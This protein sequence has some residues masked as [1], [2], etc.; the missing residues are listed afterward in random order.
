MAKHAIAALTAHSRLHANAGKDPFRQNLSPHPEDWHCSGFRPVF[1][2]AFLLRRRLPM[3][4]F[5]HSGLLPASS[6]LQQRGAAPEFMPI[7][8]AN[9]PVSRFTFSQN[10][11]RGT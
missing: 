5:L 2:L 1:W 4:P 8:S 11:E 7:P 3:Q 6:G 9:P 10:R